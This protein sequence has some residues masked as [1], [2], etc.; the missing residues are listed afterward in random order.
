[1]PM[2]FFNHSSPGAVLVDDVGTEFPSLEAAYL[3]TCDAVLDIA[4]EKLRAQ[5]NPENDSFD[6]MDGEGRMLMHVPFSEVLRPR[7]A[8]KTSSVYR[9][10]QAIV[11]RHREIV[12]SQAEL[13]AE[14][15]KTQSALKTIRT[16]LASL[17]D[18]APP[19]DSR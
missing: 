8:P 2:F 17:P 18:P 3:D 7:G 4:F 14:F 15:E 1:M 12:R 10:H 6:I 13:R 9:G 19:Q 5:Q 16:T 11:A